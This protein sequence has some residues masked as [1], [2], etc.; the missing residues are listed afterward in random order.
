MDPTRHPAA[1]AYVRA[2]HEL[3]FGEPIEGDSAS[4]ACRVA[5][6]E[7]LR[8]HSAFVNLLR[9]LDGRPTPMSAIPS[10]VAAAVAA[11]ADS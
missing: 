10:V 7:R 4:A 1:E 5:L 11:L 3:F 9:V 6:G 2:Q 8:E